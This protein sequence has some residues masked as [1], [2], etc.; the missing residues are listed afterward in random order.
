VW[1]RSNGH[2][3]VLYS[4]VEVGKSASLRVVN[5]VSRLLFSFTV[6]TSTEFMFDDGE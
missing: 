3:G 5:V 4:A 2:H 1:L 6:F